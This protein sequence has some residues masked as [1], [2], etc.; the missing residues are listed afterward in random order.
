MAY[1]RTGTAVCIIAAVVVIMKMAAA[2]GANF[3]K[4]KPL[5]QLGLIESDDIGLL[6]RYSMR[7]TQGPSEGM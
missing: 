2:R 7:M 6:L 3:D 4:T 1:E 5:Y